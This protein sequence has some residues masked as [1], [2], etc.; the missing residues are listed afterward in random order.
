[1]QTYYYLRDSNSLLR[2][3]I[4]SNL[5]GKY[6]L[7]SLGIKNYRLCGFHLK[8][9]PVELCIWFTSKLISKMLSMRSKCVIVARILDC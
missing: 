7:D 9:Y 5:I 4:C 1:M 8:I 6:K 3:P 2:A